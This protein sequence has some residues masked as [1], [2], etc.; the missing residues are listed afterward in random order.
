MRMLHF[1]HT[2]FDGIGCAVVLRTAFPNAEFDTRFVN[3]DC[4]NRI[5]E[6]D[7]SKCDKTFITDLSSDA[8]V[9][10]FK[11]RDDVVI[12][13]HH[14]RGKEIMTRNCR[15]AGSAGCATE[16]LAEWLLDWMNHLPG[17][18]PAQPFAEK[19]KRFAEMVGIVDL[20]KRDDPNFA[21]AQRMSDL[22][23]LF[24]NCEASSRYAVERFFYQP[25][26][27]PISSVELGI[28]SKTENARNEAWKTLLKKELPANGIMIWLDGRGGG[29]AWLTEKLLYE[30]RY[31]WL[32][33]VMENDG[34]WFVSVRSR[35]EGIH[36]GEMLR[37][38]NP[39]WG[40]H[41]KACGA[42]VKSREEGEF[43]IESLAR[44]AEEKH[45][46]LF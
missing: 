6:A 46:L 22:C 37:A 27:Y 16:M 9:E 28:E 15:I 35:L 43:V 26:L 44:E 34:K 33:R 32:G 14:V 41:A 23:Y 36:F 19:T 38:M 18:I 42:V 30:K 17:S 10:K 1:T 40:G 45:R 8:I 3:Y 20:Y 29:M 4:L 12:I 11:K 13:D 5:L 24:G 2:D 21:E 31:G 7:V 25:C 39:A